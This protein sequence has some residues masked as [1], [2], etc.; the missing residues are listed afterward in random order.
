MVCSFSAN[1]TAASDPASASA[2]SQR[3]GS[4]AF[5][6]PAESSLTCTM[7]EGGVDWVSA[8]ATPLRQSVYGKTAAAL[9][10]NYTCPDPPTPMYPDGTQGNPC[11]CGWRNPYTDR[12]IVVAINAAVD[13]LY[14]PG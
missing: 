1:T 3:G 14:C 6:L 5:L 7:G 9:P 8:T 13:T 2:Q 10:A 11:D 12:D 4:C